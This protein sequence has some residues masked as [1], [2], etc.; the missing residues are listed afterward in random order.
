MIMKTELIKL[1]ADSA[2]IP[3]LVDLN[4]DAFPENERVPVEEMF[5]FSDLS[6]TDILGIYTENEFSGFIIVRKAVR[7]AYI[8]YFAVC[9]E[10]RSH[11]I[12]SSVLRLLPDYYPDCQIVVDFEALDD[13]SENN[14]Q[15]IRRRNFYYRNGFYETG[16]YQFYMETE[17]EI[18]C[19]N[20]I[21]DKSAFENMIA[22]IHRIVPEFN[23][24]LYKK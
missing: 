13:T 24:Q 20:E 7:C 1:S 8:A 15:R 5:E 11:G 6:G 22:E 12:G 18:A 14:P 9:A 16:Y 23:P 17:F 3:K 19:T 10:K 2:D 21:F 4:N